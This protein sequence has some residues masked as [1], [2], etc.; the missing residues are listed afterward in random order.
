LP[1]RRARPWRGFGAGGGRPLEFAGDFG[2]NRSGGFGMTKEQKLRAIIRR[3]VTT[4][5]MYNLERQLRAHAY[6]V[7]KLAAHPRFLEQLIDE[8]VD[9]QLGIYGRVSDE[10][11]DLA[12]KFFIQEPAGKEWCQ[13]AAEFNSGLAEWSQRFARDII[14]RLENLN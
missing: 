5:F 4:G 6:Y 13:L 11:A 9:Y 1:L 8:M 12:Y 10:A 7:Q 2:G 14:R 3:D